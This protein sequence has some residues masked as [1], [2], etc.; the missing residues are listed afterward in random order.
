MKGLGYGFGPITL[1]AL[2]AILVWS[3]WLTLVGALAFVAVK[4]VLWVLHHRPPRS[5]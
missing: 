1:C 5:Q 2:K 3:I 4:R